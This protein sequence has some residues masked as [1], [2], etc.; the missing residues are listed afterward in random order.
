MGFAIEGTPA[1]QGRLDVPWLLG[2]LKAATN[3]DF[4]AILELWPP[5]VADIENTV[6]KEAAWAV[7]SVN[8]LRT[9]ISD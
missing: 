5:P 6:Q 9:L 8:Y 1:G 3:R 2:E 4:N 7:E